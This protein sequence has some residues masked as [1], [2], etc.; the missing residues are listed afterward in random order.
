MKRICSVCL[1][2]TI[3]CLFFASCG[4]EETI[5]IRTKPVSTVLDKLSGAEKWQDA[6]DYSA[7]SNWLAYNDEGKRADVIYFYPGLYEAEEG[8]DEVCAVDNANMRA[9]APKYLSTQAAVFTEECN[10]YA[11]FYRQIDKS[12]LYSVE[13]ADRERLFEYSASK[14]ASA[15]L[16]YYFEHCNNGKPFILAGHDQGSDIVRYLVGVY[17]NDHPEYM[18][19]LIAAYAIGTAVTDTF[20]NKYHLKFASG[21]DNPSLNIEKISFNDSGNFKAGGLTIINSIC[22]CPFCKG[23]RGVKRATLDGE[24]CNHPGQTWHV[25]DGKETA[26]YNKWNDLMQK[27]SATIQALEDIKAKKAEIEKLK[28]KKEELK[29]SSSKNKKSS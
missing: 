13:R 9:S 10:L 28:A 20:L 5:T 15:A 22:Y 17:L 6:V 26:A 11:P 12:F 27:T 21:E 1:L 3:V 14:D 18:S 2:L 19:R 16:D 8:G 25:M 29:K 23:D 4:G 24:R 7:Q